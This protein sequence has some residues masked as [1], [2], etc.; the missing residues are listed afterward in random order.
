MRNRSLLTRPLQVVL[1]LLG[2][3]AVVAGL[4]TVLTGADGMPGDSRATPNV[5]S[6]LRFYAVFW[7]AF[8]VVALRA[9][10]SPERHLLAI[11][12][13]ALFLFL[14]GVARG[15]AWVAEGR[16]DAEFL[17]LMALE[18]LLPVFFLVA[19]RNLTAEARRA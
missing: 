9:A 6:E 5:E 1:F 11:R 14:G 10:R 12:G 15:V 2:L 13:L 7:T 16:P 18:L 8:G 17:V 4:V 3:V 19:V